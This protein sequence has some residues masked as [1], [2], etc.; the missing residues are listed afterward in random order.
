MLGLLSDDDAEHAKIFELK[1]KQVTDFLEKNQIAFHSSIKHEH[2][3]AELT[4]KFAREIKADLITIMTEQE[5]DFIFLGTSAQKI[6]NHS[7]IPVL[8]IS[9]EAFKASNFKNNPF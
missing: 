9:P 4:L 1:I 2:D 3:H 5:S 6:V 7:K 8:S